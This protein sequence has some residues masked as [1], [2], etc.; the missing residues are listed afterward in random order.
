MTNDK[1]GIGILKEGEGG[2][3]G[4][5]LI[6]GGREKMVEDVCGR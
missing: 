1:E 4:K 6:L 3:A 5:E 2:G